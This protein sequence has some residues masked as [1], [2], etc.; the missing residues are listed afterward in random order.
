MKILRK[1]TIQRMRLKQMK[2]VFEGSLEKFKN[3]KQDLLELDKN[4]EITKL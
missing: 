2:K 4:E 3:N 1:L